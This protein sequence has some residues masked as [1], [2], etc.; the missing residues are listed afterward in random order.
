MADGIGLKR[1]P[2][3]VILNGQS[4]SA[5]IDIDCDGLCALIM[6]SAWTVANLT[7]QASE[8]L[9]GVYNNVYDS[10]GTELQITAAASRHITLNPLNFAGMR[11]IK[12]RSGT[13]GA[14]VNQAADRIIVPLARML[15]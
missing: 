10:S 14:A 12:V 13:S 4:L 6:P 7:F 11:F 9:A 5:A 1:G 2:Q 15:S 3:I 8:S